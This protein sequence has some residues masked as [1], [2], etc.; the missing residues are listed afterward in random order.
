MRTWWHGRTGAQEVADQERLSIPLGS[1]DVLVTSKKANAQRL[2]DLAQHS[3]VHGVFVRRIRHGHLM[4]YEFGGHGLFKLLA[5]MCLGW[6]IP[7]PV[8]S[9]TRS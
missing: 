2:I 5:A 3:V 7:C 6:A 9:T 8:R 4:V 1:V